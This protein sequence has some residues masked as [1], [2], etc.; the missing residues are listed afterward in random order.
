MA[1]RSEVGEANQW[2][3]GRDAAVV[4]SWNE[5]SRGTTF[6][7]GRLGIGE[8]GQHLQF[9]PAVPRPS[10]VYL[11]FTF[12]NLAA[13]DVAGRCARAGAAPEAKL[14]ETGESKFPALRATC[15][16]GGGSAKRES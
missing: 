13:T 2:M 8:L 6:L 4:V 7:R 1:A 9:T 12:R 5:G 11:P 3:E 14:G 16:H 10:H 15:G